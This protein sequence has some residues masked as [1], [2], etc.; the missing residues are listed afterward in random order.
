MGSNNNNSHNLRWGHK[1]NFT[2]SVSSY[3]RDAELGPGKDFI[4]VILISKSSTE[5]QQ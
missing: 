5:N 3:L 2:T 1:T 4:P